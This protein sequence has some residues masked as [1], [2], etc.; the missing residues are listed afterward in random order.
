MPRERVTFDAQ[1]P[2]SYAD[3]L[4]VTGDRAGNRDE[5][6]T[7]A[8]ERQG[9]GLRLSRSKTGKP[10]RM[11]RYVE[12]RRHTDSDGDA[13][14]EEGVRAALEIGRGLA[15]RYE[16]LVSSGAQRATQTLACLACMLGDP[17]AGGAV[18]EAGLRSSVEDRWRAAY[19]SAGSGELSALRAADPELVREDSAVLAAALRRVLERLPEAGRAL[20]VGHSPTNEAAVLGLTGVT[21]EPMSKG[22][23]VLVVSDGDQVRVEPVS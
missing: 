7:C 14:T 6:V 13:L 4:G 22:S 10:E 16:L 23:G 19:Q 8:R 20:A 5:E 9:C 1:W 2:R 15:G 12:L 18:V 11:A 17:V 3:L 21:I